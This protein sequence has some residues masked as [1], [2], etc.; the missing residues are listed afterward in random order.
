MIL[1]ECDIP[2]GSL[3]HHFKSKK[4]MVLS[5]IRERISPAMDSFYEFEKVDNEHPI[6]TVISSILKVAQKDELIKNGCP[7]N[8]LNQEMSPIDKD[9][10]QEIDKIYR[11]I[12]DK[13]SLLLSSGDIAQADSLA[14]HI[15]AS[16]WGALSLSPKHSCKKR[17]LETLSHL[18]NYLKSLKN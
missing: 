17:Y 7:L 5:V 8:R 2:K 9:F 11:K 10:E 16:V 18:I 15:I 4:E 13:I 3:Y 14:E 12:R 6:D 1:K